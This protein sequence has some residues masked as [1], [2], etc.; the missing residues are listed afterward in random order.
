M[1]VDFFF[2]LPT[3]QRFT[4]LFF[5]RLCPPASSNISAMASFAQVRASLSW[6]P[7]VT[8]LNEMGAEALSE[9]LGSR[10]ARL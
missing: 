9:P 4:T 8:A 5:S 3:T 1:E 10:G 7:G 6:L 2:L